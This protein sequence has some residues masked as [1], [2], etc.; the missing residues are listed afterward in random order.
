MTTVRGPCTSTDYTDRGSQM[1]RDCR[2][3]GTIFA[4]HCCR[5]CDGRL[6]I[7]PSY[8]EI[9]DVHS[10]TR[11]SLLR[12][13]LAPIRSSWEVY[14][15]SS[16]ADAQRLGERKS[17]RR[18]QC[19]LL[20]LPQSCTHACVGCP[21]EWLGQ[22]P[23]MSSTTTLATIATHLDE[24]IRGTGVRLPLDARNQCRL[25]GSL[26]PVQFAY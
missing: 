6:P 5:S 18:L 16:G 1:R 8:S 20:I 7:L 23:R 17:N 15:S 3:G 26:L 4:K 11:S 19:L 12:R 13:I 9:L 14:P 21:L 24:S 2:V 10:W 22:G 25:C